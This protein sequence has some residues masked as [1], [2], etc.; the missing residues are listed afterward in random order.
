MLIITDSRGCQVRNEDAGGGG[1]GGSGILRDIRALGQLEP[2]AC[3]LDEA[4]AYR[5]LH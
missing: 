4:L 5:L 2:L 3:P 1:K